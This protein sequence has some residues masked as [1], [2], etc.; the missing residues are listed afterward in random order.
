MQRIDATGGPPPSRFNAF[1]GVPLATRDESTRAS[2]AALGST[3]DAAAATAAWEAALR[4]PEWERSPVWIHG[5]LDARNLLARDGRITAVIDWGC[6]GVG[7]PACDVAVAWKML[8]ADARDVFRT[9][10]SV[11]D[12]TWA[13]G[14]GWVLS[15]ALNALSYYTLET[16]A[17]LVREAERW[18]AEAVGA[19]ASSVLDLSGLLGRGRG[20]RGL[21]PQVADQ[22]VQIRE[23]LLEVALV[24]LQALQQLGAVREGAAETESAPVSSV[25]SMHRSPPFGVVAVEERG[26]SLL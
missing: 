5:D 6:L 18:L 22:V 10:L 8:D 11:D 24:R 20:V 16:N 12:A 15:Q 25:S 3:I 9:A 14:R 1:R 2:I 17:V 23:L 21:V 26:A 13:R 4:A 7:D 19:S